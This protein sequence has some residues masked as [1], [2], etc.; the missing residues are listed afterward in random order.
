MYFNTRWQGQ[1]VCNRPYFSQNFKWPAI[2]GCQFIALTQSQGT[3]L[4]IYLYVHMITHLE[5]SRSSFLSQHNIFSCLGQP[6]SFVVPV[7]WLVPYLLINQVITLIYQQG[8]SMRLEYYTYA[9]IKFQME[10]YLQKLGNYCYKQIQPSVSS[11][12]TMVF[13]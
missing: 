13:P 3:F 7:S 1:L 9:H 2:P 4:G 12:P 8:Y 6:S 10:S 11:L 5:L